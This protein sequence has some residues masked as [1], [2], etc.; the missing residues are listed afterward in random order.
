MDRPS[1]EGL[2]ILE[3]RRKDSSIMKDTKDTTGILLKNIFK[4]ER[5]R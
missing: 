2:F 4:R 5:F 3:L 1:C